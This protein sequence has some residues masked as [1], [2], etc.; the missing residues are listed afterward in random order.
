MSAPMPSPPLLS[1]LS[2]GSKLANKKSNLDG[3]TLQKMQDALRKMQER[4]ARNGEKMAQ[5]NTHLNTLNKDR[6]SL[7]L[8]EMENLPEHLVPVFR[9]VSEFRRGFFGT[10]LGNGFR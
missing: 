9:Q 4:V 10:W 5:A 8:V 7:L 3:A 1:F 6:I 2:Q